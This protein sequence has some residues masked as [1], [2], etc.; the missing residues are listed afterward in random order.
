MTQRHLLTVADLATG[1]IARMLVKPDA[2]EAWA[3]QHGGERWC[4]PLR[5][6][7]TELAAIEWFSGSTP[8]LEVL[9]DQ[10]RYAASRPGEEIDPV[11][12][13]LR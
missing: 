7:H 9:A 12:G 4:R 6:D 10:S 2:V 3:M 1:S 11:Q 5:R 8:V 13:R